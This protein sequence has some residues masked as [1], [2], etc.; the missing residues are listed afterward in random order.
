MT[1]I[2]GIIN[3]GVINT[4]LQYER[5][6]YISSN[7]ANYNTNGYKA[8]RFEQVL[9]ENGYLTGYERTDY[10]NG[11]ITRTGH[12][13]D[14][15]IDGQGFIP[16]TS[17]T[18]DVVYTRD[19]S[20]KLDKDG[21]IITNDG[22]LVGDGIQL[23]VNYE[24]I[25]INTNGDIEIFSNDGT[26]RELLGTIP[27]VTFR[28]PEGL[29]FSDNNKYLLTEESGD[30]ILEKNHTKFLQGNLESTNVDLFNEV[31]QLLRLNASLLASN[32]VMSA[33]NKMYSEM[34]QLNQ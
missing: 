34:L 1:T 13:L 23:P 2:Q 28:N 12:E 33:V 9:N 10:S 5:M 18:G 6:S 11:A 32:K 3:K 17:P 4:E 26:K 27:L 21:Y 7:V 25:K 24:N 8:M 19:A 20:F 14:I 29:K 31:N 15:A 22:Y 30:P 16:V